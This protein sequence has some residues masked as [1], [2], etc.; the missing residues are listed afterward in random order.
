METDRESS[1]YTDDDDD[2]DKT[3]RPY[4]LTP[5]TDV[6]K[7]YGR[8]KLAKKEL[9]EILGKLSKDINV[10]GNQKQDLLAYFKGARY[11]LN[12]ANSMVFYC[13]NLDNF[14]ECVKSK[15]NVYLFSLFAL[16]C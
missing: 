2:D 3:N 9:S 1:K 8:S 6:L 7:K 12:T 10:L 13:K 11:A 15:M 16:A 5:L 14:A 4:C